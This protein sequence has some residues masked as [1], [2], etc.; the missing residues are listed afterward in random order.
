MQQRQVHPYVPYTPAI[1]VGTAAMIGR[2]RNPYAIHTEL[3]L[4]RREADRNSGTGAAGPGLVGSSAAGSPCTPLR[5][6]QQWS[7][8]GS[9]DEDGWSDGAGHEASPPM[10]Q[11]RVMRDSIGLGR[12]RCFPDAGVAFKVA[13]AKQAPL[14]SSTGDGRQPEP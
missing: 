5:R 14:R 3:V 4:V 8:V 10:L 12:S 13:F 11:R 6:R 1:P 7:W 2:R 9:V